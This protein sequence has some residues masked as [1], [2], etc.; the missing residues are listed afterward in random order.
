MIEIDLK[1]NLQEIK[2]IAKFPPKSLQYGL[3]HRNFKGYSRIQS[4][5]LNVFTENFS[6]ELKPFKNFNVFCPNQ[7]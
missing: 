7:R 4:F 3:F 2:I 6:I 5:V 1:E